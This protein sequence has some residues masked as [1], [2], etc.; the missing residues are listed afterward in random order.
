MKIEEKM[1][2]SLFRAAVRAEKEYVGELCKV[3]SEEHFAS[4][5]LIALS[6]TRLQALN[7]YNEYCSS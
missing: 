3:H 7:A 1:R 6:E 2:K 4:R 5:A